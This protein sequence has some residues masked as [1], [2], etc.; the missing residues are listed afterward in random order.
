MDM[1]LRI[2]I[3]VYPRDFKSRRTAGCSACGNN[4]VVIL[5]MQSGNKCEMRVTR[6]TMSGEPGIYG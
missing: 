1:F 2:T 3:C 6:S 5:D 4:A